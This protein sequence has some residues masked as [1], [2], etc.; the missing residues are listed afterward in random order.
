MLVILGFE[1]VKLTFEE[2]EVSFLGGFDTV[3]FEEADCEHVTQVL[4][5]LDGFVR[6]KY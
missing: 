6:I 5:L 4:K 3:L 1:F 2:N